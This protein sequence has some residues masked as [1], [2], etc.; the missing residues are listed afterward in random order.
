MAAGQKCGVGAGVIAG[1]VA[2]I[3]GVLLGETA[4]D[5]DLA[6][7]RRERREGPVELEGAAGALGSPAGQIDPVGNAHE[8]HAQRGAAGGGGERPA[9]TA[10][11]AQRRHDH[12]ASQPA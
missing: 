2:Q 11:R 6:L 9:P 1:A 4:E 12:Q 5:L 10:Q 7:E 8:H 3:V